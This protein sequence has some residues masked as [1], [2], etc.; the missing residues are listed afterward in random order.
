MTREMSPLFQIIP[1]YGRIYSTS[2]LLCQGSEVFNAR[3]R[4]KV[5]NKKK[6]ASTNLTLKL[7]N[8]M[9][10][11]VVAMFTIFA[12]LMGAPMDADAARYPPSN[13]RHNHSQTHDYHANN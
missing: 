10:K 12:L 8:R 2:C 6:E 13:T 3:Q 5:Q 7:F 4:K 9:G 1:R 11:V